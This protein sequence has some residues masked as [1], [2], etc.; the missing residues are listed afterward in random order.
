MLKSLIPVSLSIAS[1]FLFLAGDAKPSMS[2][3][4]TEPSAPPTVLTTIPVRPT[5]PPV[6]MRSLLQQV[7]K[8]TRTPIN[9]LKVTESNPVTFDGCMG[10]YRPNQAC[11]KIAISG[12]KSIVTGPRQTW[13]YHLNSNASKIIRNTTASGAGRKIRVSFELFGGNVA[14][15]NPNV[16]FQSSLSGDLTGRTTIVQLTTDRKLTRFMFGPTI[17]TAPVVLKTLTPEQFN[18]FKQRVE[19]NQFPNLNGL[20][21]LTSAALADYPTTTYQMQWGTTQFIDL[22]K[23]QLP[24]SLQMIIQDWERLI[25]S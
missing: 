23:K 25:K 24:R 19:R 17:K 14:D 9:Q 20:S 1:G 6:V 5:L 15:V 21:Y 11:T 8:E 7:S 10:I 13:V 18:A 12:W 16:V 22:E 4:L 2:Q 3:V